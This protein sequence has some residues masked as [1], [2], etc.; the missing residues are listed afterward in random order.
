M[1]D[2][3]REYNPAAYGIPRRCDTLLPGLSTRQQRVML[4]QDEMFYSEDGRALRRGRRIAKRTETC[5]PC[6]IWPKD[7]P[8]TPLQGV[9]LDINPHG[10]LVRLLDT[11]PAGTTIMVQ[12]MRD[13]RFTEPLAAP[14]EGRIVRHIENF[15]GFLDHGVR[16]IQQPIKKAEEAKPVRPGPKPAA[17]RPTTNRMHIID[18]TVGDKGPR[19]NR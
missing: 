13:E 18:Y 15:D 3:T 2:S 12:L 1:I 11:I 19:R 17:A 5:R 8:E 7:A 16:L 14:L 10:M 6:L 9:V 4:M